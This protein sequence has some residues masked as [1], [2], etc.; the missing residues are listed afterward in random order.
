MVLGSMLLGAPC[1]AEDSS[2]PIGACARL[3]DDIKQVGDSLHF[4]KM[5]GGGAEGMATDSVLGP[6]VMECGTDTDHMRAVSFTVEGKTLSDDQRREASAITSL[7]GE[8]RADW[9]QDQIAQCFAR[10]VERPHGI[11]QMG[12]WGKNLTCMMTDRGRG[13]LISTEIYR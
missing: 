12:V 3:F 11:V 7:L 10:A 9:T 13:V 2:N 8:G 1:H 4:K 5:L 6:I